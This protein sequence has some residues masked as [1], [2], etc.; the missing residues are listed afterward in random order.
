MIISLRRNGNS[1]LPSAAF[2]CLGLLL[3]VIASTIVIALIPIYLPHRNGGQAR[4]IQGPLRQVTYSLP[5]GT[6]YPIGALT[7]AQLAYLV[8]H[9]IKSIHEG[10]VHFV[11]F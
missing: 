3:F 5:S 4:S 9:V 1:V 2:C 6:T 10:H 11:S 8:G 7:Q